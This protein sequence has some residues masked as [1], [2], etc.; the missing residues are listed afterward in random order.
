VLRGKFLMDNILGTPPPPPPPN[1][2]TLV[3]KNEKTLKA[4]TM[5]EAMAQ[6][7]KDPSCAACHSRMDPLGFAFENFDAVGRYR[8][9]A[10]GTPVDASGALPDGT[11]FDGAPGLI[12]AIMK[13]PRQFAG[14]LTERL[15]TYALGRGVEY[16]DA[17]TVRA[18]TK[19]AAQG[20]YRFASLV[21][22]VV[23][24]MPF[25]M[26][27]AAQQSTANPVRTGAGVP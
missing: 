25:Q 15:L 20:N 24:S 3:E 5:R 16:Y 14:T 1:V 27:A 11:K 10:A 12:D 21:A 26:R 7:R 23:K 9:V 2:P 18:I 6:H 8:K 19:D 13:H 4:L 22:G 17:P